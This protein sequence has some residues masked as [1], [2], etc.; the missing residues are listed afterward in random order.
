M[1][2]VILTFA[3]IMSASAYSNTIPGPFWYNISEMILTEAQQLIS[4]EPVKMVSK[5]KT[6]KISKV[7]K[8]TLK[9][10]PKKEII[11]PLPFVT[12]SGNGMWIVN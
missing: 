1:K 6:T 8:T 5:Q 7:T 3:I 9:C 4:N 11:L 2:K 12:I 10:Q